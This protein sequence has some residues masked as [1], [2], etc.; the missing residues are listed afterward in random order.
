[1]GFASFFC[2]LRES[3]KKIGLK[4]NLKFIPFHL[5]FFSTL[6]DF[7]NLTKSWKE[8]FFRGITCLDYT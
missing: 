6:P 7:S 2:F 4:E 8:S 5:L 1:M 3:Q